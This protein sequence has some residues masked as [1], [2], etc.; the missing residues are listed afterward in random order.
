VTVPRIVGV[1][2]HL[3]YMVDEKSFLVIRHGL[4]WDEVTP[5]NLLLVDE[6]GKVLKGEGK[7]EAT[8]FW[9][10]RAIHMGRPVDARCVLHTHMP[11]STTLCNLAGGK[12]EMIHQ[13]C[14]RFWN[15]I[16]YDP[17]YNGLVLDTSEGDRMCA[18]MG[19]ASV[20]M[21]ANHG[22]VVVGKSVADAFDDIYYLERAA[23]VVVKAMSTGRPLR[24]IPKEV[25]E[26]YADDD[27][28]CFADVHFESCKRK[29][30]L[31]N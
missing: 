3:S 19:N 7:C 2:N 17:A 20:L 12:L 21:H 24:A 5:E 15:R 18:A 22:V 11:W 1:C 14:L 10:H 26:S 25:C 30:R 4:T 31:L 8:A 27:P 23:E 6:K 29:V 28:L 16:A 13:N 9:I